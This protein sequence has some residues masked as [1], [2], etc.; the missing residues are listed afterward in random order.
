MKV[1]RKQHLEAAIKRNPPEYL[2]DVKAAALDVRDGEYVLS[3]ESWDAL[4]KKYMPYRLKA[5]EQKMRDAE[6][7]RIKDEDDPEREV[8]RQIQGG[9][10]G[11]AT[12]LA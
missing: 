4:R 11:K 1:I 8:R 5:N 2:D 9:C 6:M 3:D 12:S 7:R 10:C